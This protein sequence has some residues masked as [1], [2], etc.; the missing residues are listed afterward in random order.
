MR[1]KSVLLALVLTF[2]FGPL[3]LL[4]ASAWGA[5]VLIIVA[6][7]GVVPTMGFVLMFVWPAAMVWGAIAA[8]NQHTEFVRSITRK[9]ILNDF[10]NRLDTN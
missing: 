1:D 6:A 4:Y 8:N 10:I 2:F 7:L 9:P 3:G 5:V